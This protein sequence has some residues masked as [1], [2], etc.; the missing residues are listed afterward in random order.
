MRGQTQ[1]GGGDS[2]GPW[3][4]YRLRPPD[5]ASG[6]GPVASLVSSSLGDLG[7]GGSKYSMRVQDKD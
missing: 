1:A 6:L 5:K 2:L 7:M 3:A 4:G